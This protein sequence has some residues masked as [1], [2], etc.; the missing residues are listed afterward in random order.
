VLTDFT[1]DVPYEA[2]LAAIQ[3]QHH[4]EIHVRVLDLN[5]KRLSW[6]HRIED[7]QV[8]L[9]VEDEGPSRTASI[10]LLDKSHSIGWEPDSP[11]ALP[12]HLRRMIQVFDVRFVKGYGPVSC[13]VFCGPVTEVDRDGAEVSVIAV[14]KE[15]L[16]MGS[17]G[18]AN[19]W[20]KGRLITDVISE[21]LQLAGEKPERI[22]LPKLMGRLQK[23]FNVSRTDQPLAKAR[24]L[25]HNI[26]CVLFYNGRGHAIIRR[27]PTHATLTINK[28]WLTDG[29]RMDRAPLEFHNRWVVQGKKPKG[30]KPRPSVD[31]WLPASNEF[32]G[33]ALG[34]NGQP[35]WYTKEIDRPQIE[36]KDKL[37][38]I[39]ERARDERIRYQADVSFDSLPFPNVEEWDLLK[40]RDPLA[41]AALVQVK[42]ATIPLWEGSQT[43][44]AIRRVSRLK[45][46][47]NLAASHGGL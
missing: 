42:Q 24:H 15:H 8:D 25:A 43:I 38:Q 7:G 31:V 41:G 44:G 2:W 34:R 33:V 20:A 3:R 35:R 26:D 30:D 39:A 14:G 19:S 1:D 12:K 40:A 4:R 36:D 18:K 47:G 9:N 10:Q 16:A 11:S 27:K 37:R 28:N 29:V 6:I 23:E 17:F 22:H 46:H 13:P 32:S 45:R 21:I 5:H